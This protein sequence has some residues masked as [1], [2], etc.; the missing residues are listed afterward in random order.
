MPRKARKRAHRQGTVYQRG[1]R[2]WGVSWREGGRRRYS[3]GY[4]TREIAEQ[5]RAKIVADIAAGRAGLPE[6]PK[7]APMLASLAAD[8]IERRLKTHR[9][10]D[11]DRGRWKNHLGP[12]FGR[13]RPTEVDAAAIRLFIERK[14]AEGLNAATVGHCVRLL[15][16]FFRELVERGLVERNPVSS[17][18]RATRRLYRPTTDPRNTPFLERVADI[19]RVFVALD[20]PVSVAFAIGALA[21]LRTGEVLALDWSHVDLETRRLRI[22]EQVQ[23]GR[24]LPFTKDEEVRLVPIQA[25]LAP[26][27][28]EWKLRTGGTGRLFRPTHPGGGRPGSPPGFMRPHTLHGHLKE[29]LETCKLPPITWY[30]ATR[31][32][33]ASQWV[34]AG[35]SIEKLAQIMGHSSVVVTERYAHLRTDLFRDADYNVVTVDLSGAPGQILPMRE[36]TRAGTFGYSIATKT[37]KR[38]RASSVTTRI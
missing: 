34:L 7:D 8:W 29:A 24:L 6:E 27:L 28:A 16:T 10:A 25:S 26:L 36:G 13:L 19:R 17:L 9:A 23:D 15:S 5:I 3:G 20:A 14:L 4:E 35:G 33:F 11:T 2:N 37:K 32:T 1:P 12:C 22:H 30:Q 38:I 18:P 31:H 21:G